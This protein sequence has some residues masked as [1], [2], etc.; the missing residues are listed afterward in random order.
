MF[1]ADRVSFWSHHAGPEF[2]QNLKR[3]LIATKGKL[4]L[5]LDG[6][7]SGNLRSHQVG[8]PKPCRKGRMARLHDRSGCQRGVDLAAAATKDDGRTRCEAIRLFD[9]PAFRTRKP[10]RPTHS[11]EVASTCRVVWEHPLKLWQGSGEAAMNVHGW[12]LAD[13]Y[14]VVKQPD[15]HGSNHAAYP[16][17]PAKREASR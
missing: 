6:R 7:L 4:A 1:A 14:A 12:T 5:E 11:F 8:A 15:K 13:R 3:R 10:V 17:R 2:V 16:F 9:E